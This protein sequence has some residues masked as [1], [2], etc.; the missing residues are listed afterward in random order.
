MAGFL[1]Y[2]SHYGRR[3]GPSGEAESHHGLDIAAPL[4]SPVRS[5]W[6]GRIV[7]VILDQGCGVGLVVRSGAWEH[8]YCHLDGSVQGGLYRAEGV[9]MAVGQS[10]RL[11]QTIGRVGVSGR[12]TGPH[13]HWGLR[14]D[15]RWLDPAMILRAMAEARRQMAPNERPEPRVGLSR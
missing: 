9:Q 8:I 15:G 14:Y 12:T 5:W 1:A 2:T 11:G 6:S 13:L 4:G 10:V 3:P 7:E